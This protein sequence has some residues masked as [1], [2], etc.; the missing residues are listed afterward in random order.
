M[1]KRIFLILILAALG[2]GA[3]MWRTGVFAR[4]GSRILVSGNLELTEVDLSFKIAGKL[5]ERN[6]REGDWVKMHY[7]LRGT[8]GNV[9]VHYFRNLTTK[10]DVEFKFK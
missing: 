3:W 6:V 8:N 10:M 1:K 9:T 7:V 4:D 5:T 2:A